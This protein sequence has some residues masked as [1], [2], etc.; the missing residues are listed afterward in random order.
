MGQTIGYVG[1]VN[2]G[3]CEPMLHFELYSGKLT[4][5]LTQSGTKFQRRKDLVNPS[6]LLT[7]LEKL[8][9][10]VAYPSP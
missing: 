6:A 4:G 5:A 1:K 8:K 7:E 3:C 9:F 2:S 10:G